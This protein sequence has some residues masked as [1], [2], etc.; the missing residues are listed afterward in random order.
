MEDLVWKK[1][2]TAVIKNIM[3]FFIRLAEIL[4]SS[5]IPSAI[6]LMI[7]LFTPKTRVMQIME[8]VSFTA[9]FV[10]SCVFWT[11]YVRHRPNRRE[12]Y[13]MNG[14]AYLVYI[15]LSVT[16]YM[17]SDVYLYSIFFSDMRMLEVFGQ[18]TLNSLI[19]THIVLVAAMILTENIAHRYYCIKA[20]IATENGADTVEID[21]VPVTPSKDNREVEI[22]SVDEVNA[23]LEREISEARLMLET[24]KKN[25]SDK[26]WNDDMVK[27]EG[28]KIIESMPEDPENDIDDEDFVSEAYAR[29]EMSV[30]ENYSEDMLWNND[31]YKGAAPIDCYDDEEYTKEVFG[32]TEDGSMWDSQICKG[33]GEA[34]EYCDDYDDEN[35]VFIVDYEQ[36]L[37]TYTPNDLEAYDTD[38]LWGEIK[39]GRE[40]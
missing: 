27:G 15:S 31:I 5:F 25:C 36:E 10:T 17:L 28:E 14:L 16:I 11:K 19:F 34:L 7:L 32:G 13:I 39:K 1:K 22:M 21:Y 30:T 23:E 37:N 35:T 8:C 29:R 4:T 2:S 18:T 20:E 38:N 9:F 33:R 26:N 40:K 24:E 3:L 12:F 6:G